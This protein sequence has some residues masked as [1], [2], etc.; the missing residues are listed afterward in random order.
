MRWPADSDHRGTSPPIH[1]QEEDKKNNAS[2]NSTGLKYVVV[3]LL[4][5]YPALVSVPCEK[6]IN[7]PCCSASDR[8]SFFLWRVSSGENENAEITGRFKWWCVGTMSPRNT[9][10]SPPWLNNTIWWP[11]ACPSVTTTFNPGRISVSPSSNSNWDFSSIGKKFS[12]R[13]KA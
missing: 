13:W 4:S 8:I 6:T 3:P 7:H 2:Y 12:S 5:R 9:T 11:I 10:L 1:T